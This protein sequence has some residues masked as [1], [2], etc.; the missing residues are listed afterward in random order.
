[1]PLLWTAYSSLVLYFF[2]SS[3]SHGASRKALVRGNLSKLQHKRTKEW[4][5][6][7][8]KKQ[9]TKNWPYI[10]LCVCCTSSLVDFRI[11]EHTD[12]A[13]LSLYL[14][15]WQYCCIPFVCSMHSCWVVALCLLT[16]SNKTWHQ[17]IQAG[18]P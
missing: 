7:K 3:R 13:C 11:L 9:K 5:L 6:L 4:F 18:T 17:F 2:K 12:L 1:M 10:L 14:K 15:K 16:W 8:L